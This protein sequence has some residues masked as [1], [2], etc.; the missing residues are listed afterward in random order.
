MPI[1]KAL[2]LSLLFKMASKRKSYT[3][4]FK[5]RAIED[6]KK[7]K[8]KKDVCKDLDIAPSTLSTFLKDAGQIISVKE[9]QKFHS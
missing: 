2:S 7:G 9:T 8:K 1:T 6:V 3:L 5:L 4:E